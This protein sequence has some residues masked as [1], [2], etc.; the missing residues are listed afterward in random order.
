MLLK[1]VLADHP[2]GNGISRFVLDYLCSA[3]ETRSFDEEQPEYA[4]YLLADADAG[5]ADSW[6]LYLHKSDEELQ[7]MGLELSTFS[8]K[9]PDDEVTTS[10]ITR[11]VVAGCKERLLY[12]REAALKAL[13]SGFTYRGKLDLDLQW[14]L[15]QHRN[16]DLVLLLQGRAVLNVQDMVE[17]FD[18]K[19]AGDD[20]KTSDD[21]RDAVDFL[22]ELLTDE[23]E[24][25]DA[26]RLLLLRWCTGLNAV[27]VNGLDPKV[28]LLKDESGVADERLPLAHTC[29]HE[30]DLPPYSSKAVLCKQLRRA[31]DEF[32]LDP[33][34]HE[35]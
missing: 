2:L 34:F 4:L 29:S 26:R 23:V 33:S 5:L 20:W 3:H 10:N 1:S 9:L 32:K 21:S 31:L 15:A 11:A 18:W 28:K 12:K 6:R 7:A 30:I 27:S 13:C 14:Q 22:R 25:D 8:D 35:L 17:V 24:F 19:K 16:A